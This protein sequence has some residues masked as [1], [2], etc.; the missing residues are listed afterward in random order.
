MRQRK[1]TIWARV[2]LLYPK[3]YVRSASIPLLFYVYYNPDP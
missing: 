2:Q 3:F 1:V